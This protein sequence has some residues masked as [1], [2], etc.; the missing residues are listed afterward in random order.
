[1]P[2]P[3]FAKSFL[4][5]HSDKISQRVSQNIK[6]NRAAVSPDVIK[7]YFTQLKISISDVPIDNIV[8]YDET[9]LADDPGRKK[10]LTK[11]GTKYPERVMNHSKSAVS[12]MMACTAAGEMLPPYV[13]YKAQNLYDTW[14]KSGPNGSRY[15]RSPSGWFDSNIFED[16][17]TTIILPFFENKPGKKC[18]VGDNLSSHLSI[19]LIKKC[20]E[21]DIHFIFLPANSTHLTQPLD[22]A[23]F[24]PMKIAW[25]NIILQ[26]K[27]TDGRNQ[28]AIPKGC[29]PK[30]LSKLMD[31]LSENGPANILSGFRKTGIHPFNPSEVLNKLPDWD[32]RHQENEA[33]D[34]TVLDFLKEMRYGTGGIVEPKKKK[35]LLVQAGKSVLCSSDDS[36][37]ENNPEYLPTSVPKER[38]TS[39][40]DKKITIGKGKGKGK[41]SKTDDKS[42]KNNPPEN[43]DDQVIASSSYVNTPTIQPANSPDEVASCLYNNNPFEIMPVIFEEDLDGIELSETVPNNDEAG[44][45]IQEKATK[46]EIISNKVL[47]N[48]ELKKI[49]SNKPVT[50]TEI[51]GSSRPSYYKNDSDILKDLMDLE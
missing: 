41:K 4:N 39:Q 9:N 18:M 42:Q 35:K 37:I 8:N 5:R 48:E 17:V 1:M 16:W 51:N 24:R 43:R 30:L 14:T 46:I 40:T 21:R 13:V 45:R 11:R 3:D 25:R 50:S 29:F 33:V 49:L 22:V 2:G 19:D 20:Q 34:E 23:F 36:Y 28:A 31:S 10:I 26:W 6:R 38:N 27:K 15:N 47:S 12:I 32:N 7:E 44:N